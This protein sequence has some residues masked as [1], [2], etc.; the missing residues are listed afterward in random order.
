MLKVSNDVKIAERVELA[1]S[2]SWVNYVVIFGSARCKL[3]LYNMSIAGQR[4]DRSAII[5]Y[6]SET[7]NALDFAEELGRITE[8][9]H[10]QTLTTN[11]DAVDLVGR[12]R[13][14][15]MTD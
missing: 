1:D 9:L 10:F 13:L 4:H 14:T 12:D 8:R 15:P 7:G 2:C 5:L 11:L 6:G 3:D